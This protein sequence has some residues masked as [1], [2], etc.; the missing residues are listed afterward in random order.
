[1]SFPFLNHLCI[2]S[3][4]EPPLLRHLS[5]AT[6]T[7]SS[8]PPLISSTQLSLHHSF[9]HLLTLSSSSPQL[10]SPA[11]H[12]I[13]LS[14][15]IPSCTSPVPTTFTPPPPHLHHL[16]SINFFSQPLLI[17][18]S[19]TSTILSLLPHLI[20]SLHA[21]TSSLLSLFLHLSPHP[22]LILFSTS[23]AISLLHLISLS[24]P[25]PFPHLLLSLLILIS[26]TSYPL[27]NHLHLFTLSTTSS[28]PPTLL[29]QQLLTL[30][31]TSTFSFTSPPSSTSSLPHHPLLLNCH[32]SVTSC[33]SLLLQFQSTPAHPHWTVFVLVRVLLSLHDLPAVAAHHGRGDVKPQ[34]LCQ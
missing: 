25:P 12:S 27:L 28:P 23:F 21:T 5:S 29:L 1:M 2:L 18:S 19:T 13:I 17:L 30:S 15:I 26:P 24:C 34:S 33:P 9:Q 6:F 10:T 14:S 4:P 3:S 20:I 7:T 11:P 8:P 22:L 16:L 32:I 31:L